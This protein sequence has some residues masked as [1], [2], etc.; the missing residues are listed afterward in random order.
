MRYGIWDIRQHRRLKLVVNLVD[1]FENR[2]A[3]TDLKKE[4]ADSKS[5]KQNI[6][7]NIDKI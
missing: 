2:F 4:R 7:R 1:I 6:L 5:K 3:A